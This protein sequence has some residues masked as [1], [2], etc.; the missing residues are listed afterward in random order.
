MNSRVLIAA[1]LLTQLLA[2]AVARADENIYFKGRLVQDKRDG[3]TI[4][5]DKDKGLIAITSLR[6][7]Y[8][9][10]LPYAEDWVFTLEGGSLLKGHSGLINLTLSADRNDETPEQYLKTHK[11]LLLANPAV[12][13][14]EKMEMVAYKEEPVLREIQ[15]GEAAS[16]DKKF[17][18]VRVYHFF[19]AKRW[20]RDL[21]LL[22]LSKVVPPKETFNEKQYLGLVT[23]GFGVDFMREGKKK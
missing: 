2:T 7:H 16:G 23:M 6:F 11:R 3:I 12:K 22:H 14:V 17:R 8:S 5:G 4:A 9:L 20:K 10:V 21:F 15:D 18:G 13:G 19:T 1:F